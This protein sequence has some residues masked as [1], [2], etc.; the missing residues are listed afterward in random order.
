MDQRRPLRRLNQKTNP[1]SLKEEDCVPHVISGAQGFPEW[2]KGFLDSHGMA[3][4]CHDKTKTV[5]LVSFVD[6][7]QCLQSSQDKFVSPASLSREEIAN[8]MVDAFAHP[9]HVEGG[10]ACKTS[11]LAIRALAVFMQQQDGQKSVRFVVVVKVASTFRFQAF[12]RSLQARRRLATHWCSSHRSYSAA[13]RVATARSLDNAPLRLGK[14]GI[15]I[16]EPSETPSEVQA[17]LG[18]QPKPVV[19][20]VEAPLFL[21]QAAA[22]AAQAAELDTASSL[23]MFATSLRFHTMLD[24]SGLSD[25]AVTAAGCVSLALGFFGHSSVSVLQHM[26]VFRSDVRAVEDV[27]FAA[28]DEPSQAEL[29]AVLPHLA[30][31]LS[32]H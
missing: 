30:G 13:L 11:R 2:Q 10:N 5:Y 28:L 15:G 7:Y 6:P 25:S 27:I 31:D 4:E 29:V 1:S 8:C 22:F 17:R 21:S 20:G 19:L 18:F 24:G 14:Q 16:T 26:R 23:Q 3:A 9:V 12:K 32:S